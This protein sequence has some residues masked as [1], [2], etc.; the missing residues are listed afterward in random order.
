MLDPISVMALLVSIPPMVVSL[1]QLQASL[2]PE[3]RKLAADKLQEILNG[4]REAANRI[5][6]LHKLSSALSRG[7]E[8][9][10]S[11]LFELHVNLA[12]EKANFRDRDKLWGKWRSLM[13]FS[14]ADIRA[15]MSEGKL[16]HVSETDDELV[17]WLK[18][19]DVAVECL[20]KALPKFCGGDNKCSDDVTGSLGEVG[21]ILSN[22]TSRTNDQIDEL[23]IAL[24]AALTQ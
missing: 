22:A 16:Q 2:V 11:G 3:D 12:K 1:R 5:R 8:I 4:L 10:D 13:K 23:L 9:Y 14:L 24:A 20:D 21:N 18:D 7:V 6:E 19:L 15:V 17:R